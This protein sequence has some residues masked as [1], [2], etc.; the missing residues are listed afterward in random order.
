MLAGLLVVPTVLLVPLVQAVPVHRGDSVNLGIDLPEDPW[1]PDVA[2]PPFG[3]TPAARVLAVGDSVTWTTLGGYNTWNRNHPDETVFVDSVMAMGCSMADIDE[4]RH[5]GDWTETTVPCARLRARIGDALREND[6]DAIVVTIGHKD[7]GAHMID[8]EW[9]SVGDPAFDRWYAGEVGEWIELL[10][11]EDVPVL[12][13]TLTHVRIERFEDRSTDWRN[14]LDADNDPDRVD[15]INRIMVDTVAS[16][17]HGEN[18]QMMDT[19]GWVAQ[20][21][22]GEFDPEVRFDGVHFSFAGSDMLADWV[23]PQILEAK[24][25]HD[26]Q[27]LAAA[28]GASPAPAEPAP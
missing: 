20:L 1:S 18:F 10:A 6:Y 11:S 7:L 22:G 9:L 2:E 3:V 5:M 26:L 23:V 27:V 19:G 25:A 12:W 21:P 8:G 17:P 16:S 13:S 24:R 15:R 4:M 14:F 28:Q